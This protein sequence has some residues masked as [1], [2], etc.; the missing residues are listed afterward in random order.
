[1][2]LSLPTE[3]WTPSDSPPFGTLFVVATPIGHMEDITLRA[4]RTL[5]DVEVIA[6]EDTRKTRK[7]LTR[8]KISTPLVSYHDHNE[9]QRTPKLLAKLKSGASIALVTDAGTP[10]ISDPGHY[11]VRAAIREAVS[12]VPIPGASA[13]IAALSVS[14]LPTDSFV[15][16]GFVPRKPG[17]RKALLDQLKQVPRTLIFYESPQRL[18]VLMQEI[19]SVMGDRKAVTA[20]ELTKVHEEVL[21]GPLSKMVQDM[22][23]GP[24]LKGEC[25][26]LVA[27]CETGRRMDRESIQNH[28]R[29]LHHEQDGSLSDLV[30]EVAREYGLPKRVVYEE[31][32]KI[33]KEG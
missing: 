30:K 10:S 6:A 28:L 23:A 15:F 13:I 12:V 22:S 5:K 17:K 19:L 14:G 26:L 2:P 20:R 11:L 4:L 29:R 8:H 3:G 31:A 27:G 1:M 16:V 7:L 33:K 18:L 24:P 25:T 9:E 21:R 32:L